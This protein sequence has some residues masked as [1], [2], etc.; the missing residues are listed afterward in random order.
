MQGRHD[1]D[2]VLKLQRDVLALDSFISGI[3]AAQEV[4]DSVDAKKRKAKSKL[5]LEKMVQA[6]LALKF[7]RGRS[8]ESV[9]TCVQHIMRALIPEALQDTLLPLSA[10]LPAE[11]ITSRA[12]LPMDTGL[13]AVCGEVDRKEGGPVYLFLWRLCAGT[14]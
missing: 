10:L 8:S 1:E 14:S 5:K 2:Y 11:A 6:M 9:R 3:E 4:T 13:S 12:L 7:V